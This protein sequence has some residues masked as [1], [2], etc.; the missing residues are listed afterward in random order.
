MVVQMK[1]KSFI[2]SGEGAIASY[3]YNDVADGTGVIIFYGASQANNS[4]DYI[5]TTQTIKSQS[6]T[7][8]NSSNVT[9]NFDLSAFNLP[10]TIKGTAFITMGC[11]NSSASN[12]PQ[13]FTFQVKKD[14]GG[15][16]T[17]CS[18]AITPAFP[19]GNTENK[20]ICAEIPLTQTNFK[21]GDILRLAI[22]IN[23]TGGS[24]KFGI[25]PADRADPTAALTASRQL[26]FYLPFRVDL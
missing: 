22:T 18:S 26:K 19:T 10:R 8:S 14:S 24:L 11:Y 7:I 5:L 3:S 2:R 17:N 16:V 6:I 15:N 21:K 13:T 1:K 12:P 4:E 20:D 25:D 23:T 9:Y